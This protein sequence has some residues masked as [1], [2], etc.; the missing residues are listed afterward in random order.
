M[1]SA[2]LCSR[3]ISTSD[4]SIGS[5]PTTHITSSMTLWGAG[6]PAMVAVFTESLAAHAAIFAPPRVFSPA[7]ASIETGS[8]SAII[9]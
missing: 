7:M 1:P 9:A 5:S 3:V 4:F 6:R 2:S 8:S